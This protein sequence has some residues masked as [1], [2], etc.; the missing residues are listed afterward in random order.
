MAISAE[1]HSTPA[2]TYADDRADFSLGPRHSKLKRAMDM[3]GSGILIA[4]LFVPF[5]FVALLIKLDSPGPVFFRQE[6]TGANGETFRI[7][8]FRSMYVHEPEN[9]PKQAVRNDPRVTRIGNFLRKTSIDELAQLINV[10]HGEMSLI[11]PRPHAKAHDDYYGVSLP[12]YYLRFH[13]KPGIT[14]LAQVR[15]QRGETK[16]LRCMARRLSSD[17]E[18]IGDWSIWMDLRI[19]ILSAFIFLRIGSAY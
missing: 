13:A 19:L 10:F 8:K 18:Y 9:N 11:G 15:C 17:L 2:F 7:W 6:R 1:V 14:G 3:L 16:T 5:L 4:L 12:S